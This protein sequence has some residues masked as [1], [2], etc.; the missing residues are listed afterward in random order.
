MAALALGAGCKQS[1]AAPADCPP[2]PVD[3]ACPDAVPSFANDIYLNV[4]VPS[5]VRCHSPNG[6]ESGSPL[7]NYQ[8]IYGT[9]G[10]EAREIY[11]Q[12][13]QSCLMPPP[14]GPEALT[15]S[16]R[17]KLLDWFGCGAPDSP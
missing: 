2:A 10:S 5:C 14:G 9:G 7:T 16:Q 12:V 11:F 15:D 4:F 6:Q 1:P 13:F 17:Q 3:P 8:Q